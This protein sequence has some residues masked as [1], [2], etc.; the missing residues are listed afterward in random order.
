MHPVV[1]TNLDFDWAPSYAT[2][3]WKDHWHECRYTLGEDCLEASLKEILKLENCRW[4][5]AS[6]HFTGDL[7][8]TDPWAWY[9]VELYNRGGDEEP[10]FDYLRIPRTPASEAIDVS[11]AMH[12]KLTTGTRKLIPLD[13]YVAHPDFHG[14]IVLAEGGDDS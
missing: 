11:S 6:D 14:K 3:F 13:W 9:C 8:G 10:A 4:V 7:S 12:H 5:R 2:F 1:T